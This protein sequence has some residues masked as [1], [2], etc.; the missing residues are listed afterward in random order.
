MP[1]VL[2]DL[3]TVRRLAAEHL[4]RDE[5][6][7]YLAEARPSVRLMAGI[8]KSAVLGGDPDVP[9]LFEWPRWDGY[10]LDFVASY[11]LAALHAADPSVPLPTAGTLLFFLASGLF[12]PHDELVGAIEPSSRPGW[13]VVHVAS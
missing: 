2:I 5:V 3:P 7:R 8:G 1:F 9:R 12:G 10:A 11:D 13:Q 6:P 4:E